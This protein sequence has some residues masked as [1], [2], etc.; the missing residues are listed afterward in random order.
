MKKVT[1]SLLLGLSLIVS[2]SSC[3]GGQK[4]DN[5]SQQNGDQLEG[6]ISFSGAFALYP[7]AV[8]WGEE[9][10]KIHPNV[11][12]EV[13]GGGAGKGMTDV[14]AGQV[15]FGMVSRE[16]SEAEAAKGAIGFPVAKDAVI[17]TINENNPFYAEL[18]KHGIS[19]AQ[20]KAIWI[21]GT[22]KTWGQLLGTSDDTQITVFTRSD[23]CGVAETWATFLGKHQEDLLGEGVNAEPG[24]ITAVTKNKLSIGINNISYVFDGNTSKPHDGIRP[25]P[26]DLNGNGQID[27]DEDFYANKD[28]LSKAVA[29]GKY[30]SPPARDMYLVTKGKPTDP[31]IK[32]FLKFVLTEGQ[33]NID[34]Y[35]AVSQEKLDKAL[36]ELNK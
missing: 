4:T 8:K 25:L 35:I 28:I 11:K 31:L 32:E 19:Q 2:V 5:Q 13:D 30:P 12:F 6:R 33:K 34:A 26:V 3:G 16:I 36:E 29:D 14:L 17:P 18:V 9:F 24:L 1:L 22:I 27:P 10:R 15:E 7:L 23:A 20:A 21:D